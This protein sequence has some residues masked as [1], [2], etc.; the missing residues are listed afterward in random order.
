MGCVAESPFWDLCF[1]FINPDCS[2]PT[3]VTRGTRRIAREQRL[4]A[5]CL[6]PAAKTDGSGDLPQG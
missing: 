4:L 1:D 6:Q 2:F 3:L 5:L